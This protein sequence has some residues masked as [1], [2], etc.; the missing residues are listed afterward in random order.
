MVVDRN[1]WRYAGTLIGVK[2]I[3]RVSHL[4]EFLPTI[5]ALD[6]NLLKI[7]VKFFSANI[8]RGGGEGG[9]HRNFFFLDL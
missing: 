5:P 6:D 2:R 1:S 8:K 3:V 4:G 9:L 7:D